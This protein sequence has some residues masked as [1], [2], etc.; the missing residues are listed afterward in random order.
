MKLPTLS[1]IVEIIKFFRP[2]FYNKATWF[3]LISGVAL[4][5]TSIFEKIL[6]V[7]LDRT[8]NLRLTETSDSYIGLAFVSLGLVYNLAGQMVKSRHQIA[9][10]N[11]AINDDALE[12]RTHDM[13]I[14][15]NLFLF[16][17]YESVEP[18]VNAASLT[19]LPINI[20]ETIS[21]VAH[22]HNTVPYELHNQLIEQQRKRF[23][24]SCATFYDAMLQFLGHENGYPENMVVP[25]YQLKQHDR[26]SFYT[27]QR[28]VASTGIEFMRE[29]DELIRF[30]K[31]ENYYRV[32]HNA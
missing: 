2:E 1:Q 6:F 15:E 4:T 11:G 24:T 3:L 20:C 12:R 9:L 16:L 22:K 8:F 26:E 27:M 17:P 19:G 18:T 23:V 5:G 28:K 25:P 32:P 14:L 29:Y 7:V 31:A 21:E 10:T 13:A 30:C